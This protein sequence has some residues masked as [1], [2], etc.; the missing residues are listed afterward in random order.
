MTLISQEMKILDRATKKGPELSYRLLELR[1][2]KLKL[3]HEKN[4]LEFMEM[5]KSKSSQKSK[6]EYFQETRSYYNS[7]KDF[8]LKM[9]KDYP[10]SK[11]RGE[12]LFALALNSR[13]YGLDNITEKFL[14]DTISLISSAEDPLKHHAET[15]LADYYYNDKR[16]VQAI[17]FYEKVIKRTEDSWLS[18]HY[19]N[20]SWCYLKSRNFE[21][22]ISSIKMSYGL[23]KNKNYIN[24][25]EQVLDNIGTFFVYSNRPLEGLDFYLKNEKDPVSYLLSMSQKTSEKGLSKETEVILDSIQNLINKN[26]WVKYQEDLYI[27]SLEFYR[28]YNRFFDFDRVCSRLVEF[29]TVSDDKKFSK[30][31]RKDEAVEKI[32][33]LSGFLQVKLSKNIKEEGGGFKK[34]ELTIVL[35]FFNHLVHLDPRNKA[36][37]FYYKGETYFSVKLF[38]ESAIAYEMAIKESKITKN[39]NVAR[40]AIDSLLQLTSNEILDRD[41]N[42]HYLIFA[43][44]EHLSLWPRH[45]KSE[46]IYPKLFGL[47]LEKKRANDASKILA[48]F[49]KFYP[50]LSVDQ[51]MLATRLMDFYIETKDTKHFAALIHQF[52]LGFLKFPNPLIEKSEITLGNMLFL[53]YQ[54]LAKKGELTSAANGFVSIHNNELYTAKIKSQSAYFASLTFLEL[55]ETSRAFDWQVNAN[56][57][58]TKE[59]RL[60]KRSDQI[61]IIE[62]IFRLQDFKT[63]FLMSSFLLKENCSFKDDIQGRLFDI[64][65]TVAL[66]EDE[67]SKAEL[68]A[69]SNKGCISKTDLYQRSITQIYNFFVR[70][71]DFRGLRSLVKK[72]SEENFV[73]DYPFVLQKW[74][75]AK[76]D[77]NLKEAI[78]KELQDLNT[79]EAKLWLSEMNDFQK[80]QVRFNELSEVAIWSNPV[81]SSA[82]FNKSLDIYL[83]SLK[84]FK[85]RFD[86]LMNSDQLDLALLSTK[87]FSN[88]YI[89]V[90]KKINSIHPVGMDELTF[91][92][93]HQAMKKV[94]MNFISLAEKLEIS[95]NGSLLKGEYLT[96]ASRIIA[97]QEQ[98]ENPVFSSYTTLIM[99]DFKRE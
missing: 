71:G 52:K 27:T 96:T 38:Y 85:T 23:S 55:G 79:P 64:A 51:H 98:I 86:Y 32:R 15:A 33:S 58:F 34:D 66:V 3:I 36:E 91:K 70:N 17:Y 72:Y 83:L 5:Y 8:G 43:Y 63:T 50:E 46:K 13:D 4:N 93:F 42:H 18:K 73:S 75:W 61:K 30:F 47:F 84:D 78:K 21:N 67:G 6:E 11:R 59:E 92:D 97:S 90:G 53:E 22:A 54:E 81:F 20:L 48:S 87:L 77:L 60:S 31:N 37:Y 25:R 9:L 14:L 89:M 29:Y 68:T 74:F 95:L 44:S 62:R 12:V 69:S 26:G 65:V 88:L 28:H 35:N 94:S 82:E 16:Y 2:E 19:F 80:A 40:K 76:A 41:I 57:L 99:D 56:K 10:Q 39:E 1:S 49:N 45:E 7:T 24:I